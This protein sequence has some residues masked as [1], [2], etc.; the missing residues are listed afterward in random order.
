MGKANQGRTKK[1]APLC[2]VRRS[3]RAPLQTLRR[4]ALQARLVP[5]GHLVGYGADGP[6]ARLDARVVSCNCEGATS[7]LT[8][9]LTYACSRIVWAHF[10]TASQHPYIFC[11]VW[12]G[13][14]GTSQSD[15]RALLLQESR[16]GPLLRCNSTSAAAASCA[17]AAP[18][19]TRRTL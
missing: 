18:H 2:A 1:N 3:P 19:L 6:L 14:F 13:S 16:A 7:T 12:R 17:R 8:T 4:A 10:H 15:M 9:D 5:G 11:H